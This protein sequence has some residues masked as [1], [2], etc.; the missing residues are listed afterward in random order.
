MVKRVRSEEECLRVEAVKET[1][2]W[3]QLI[4]SLSVNLE[5]YLT[6]T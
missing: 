4:V 2:D 1:E 5:Y 3:E 6:S